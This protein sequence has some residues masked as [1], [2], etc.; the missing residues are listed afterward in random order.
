VGWCRGRDGREGGGRAGRVRAQ[1]RQAARAR[2]GARRGGLVLVPGLRCR[3]GSDGSDGL[4]VDRWCETRVSSPAYPPRRRP[5][6]MRKLSS[7]WSLYLAPYGGG[8]AVS[9]RRAPQDWP[10]VSARDEFLRTV[11]GHAGRWGRRW[12]TLRATRG[13]RWRGA[14]RTSS[15][16]GG[17]R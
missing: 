5:L 7:L 10:D 17:T 1:G 12:V 3:D 13:G 14:G 9:K 4:M 15:R 6:L 11:A 16:R 2:S 8:E